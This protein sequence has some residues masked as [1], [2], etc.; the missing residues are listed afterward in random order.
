MPETIFQRTVD[1]HVQLKG[2]H[3]HQQFSDLKGG[4]TEQD[5]ELKGPFY[6]KMGTELGRES[7][8]S[9]GIRSKTPRGVELLAIKTLECFR[10]RAT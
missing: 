8:Q 7:Y 5:Y 4:S 10:V 1:G 2:E 6:D 3:G 9:E